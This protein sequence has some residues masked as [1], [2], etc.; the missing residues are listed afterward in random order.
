MSAGAARPRVPV[1]PGPLRRL[2]PVLAALAL[3]LVG[4]VAVAPSA[5][6]AT[7]DQI[8]SFRI[9]YALQPSGV[10]QVEETIVWRFGSDSGRHGIQRDLVERERYDD[11]QDAVYDV[12]DIRVS[13]PDPVS[14]QFTSRTTQANGG[15][16]E[17]LN[18]RIGD[19]DGTISRATAT[20]VLRYQ[21]TGA[22]RS[23]SG[24]DE[25]FWDAPGFGNPRIADLAITAS[26]PGGAQD[27][28]CFVGPPGPQSTTPCPTAERTADGARFAA[29]DVAQGSGLSFGVKIAPGLVADNKP[30]LEPDGSKLTGGQRAAAVGAGVAG[31]G[32]LVGSPLVGVLWWRRNGRDQR[33]EGLAPGTTPYAG[34]TARVVP[35]D[36]DIPIPVAFAPPKIPVAEAGL[37]ID[38]QVDARET[39]ATIVDLAV[40][41]AL[42]VHSTSDDDFRVTLLDPD[43]A[44]APH[45]MVLLTNVFGG[46]PPGATEDLSTRGSML[47]AHRAMTTSVINQVTARGWFRKVPS[48]TAT[49]GISFG[50]VALVVFLAFHAGAWALWVLLPL[51]PVVVTYLVVRS[52]LRRGQRTADGRAVC[53]QVE[54]FRT[55]LATAEAEQLR[56]EEGEDIFSRYLPWAIVFELADRWAELCGQLVAMGRIPETTPSW[57]TGSYSGA[58][59]NTAFLTSNLTAAATPAPS[60]SGSSGTG[61]GG[62]SSFGGGGFSGGGGGGGGS[63]S[64]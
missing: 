56:F 2:L 13:S 28:S 34:Q 35:N 61:F 20:Y 42:Q 17:L 53:D 25:L 63:S 40:R 38:G 30:H 44:T 45:E 50:V 18:V 21:V 47:S 22:V 4:A 39:A 23:F 55:Y 43:R 48:G 16:T 1:L 57:Y 9:A 8:D 33:Y 32:L 12:S 15:R 59:F 36:P 26:V 10:L 46:R 52:K 54:G 51:L 7:E 3:A 6:A 37:L 29:T 60:T 19:P 11:T 27:V 5:Q 31:V 58:Y 49:G 64:W 24:Y 62:G 14:T 41:G